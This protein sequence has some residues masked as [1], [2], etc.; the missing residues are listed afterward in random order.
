M[1][2]IRYLKPDFF[3]D[4]DIAALPPLVRLFY[5]GLWCNADKAGRLE[6]RPGELKVRILPYDKFDSE[7]AL[8]ILSKTKPSGR[9]FV[10]RY[11]IE[12]KRYIQILSWAEHQKPHHTE[13]ESR[14]PSPP[15]YNLPQEKDKDKGNGECR[16][17]SSELSNGSLT[18]KKRLKKQV[19][20]YF[21]QITGQNRSSSCRETSELINGRISEG[22]TFEDFKHVIDTKTA[23]WQNDLKMRKFLRPSTLFRPGNFEDYLN[24]PYQDPKRKDALKPGE[25]R[26]EDR[27]PISFR[28][29]QEIAEILVSKNGFSSGDLMRFH[30]KLKT[31]FPAIKNQFESSDK[32]AEILIRL[33]N[34]EKESLN[35]R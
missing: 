6:D 1:S 3:T 12:N 13:R 21:N 17:E 35:E 2:R 28:L 31:V 15:S 34:Q 29:W 7:A 32:S 25:A 33:V 30:S 8:K 22:R 27:S 4:E 20:L 11:Q 14:I 18:V 19:I 10:L 9:P 16:D 23:Q 26:P 5:A 24:E